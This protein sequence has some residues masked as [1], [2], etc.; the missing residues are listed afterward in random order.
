MGILV[1]RVRFENGP[2]SLDAIYDALEAR[3]GLTC[4]RGEVAQGYTIVRC[5]SIGAPVEMRFEEK[6]IALE[7][8][9]A[10]S[11][12]LFDQLREALVDLG[13][14]RCDAV[15]HPMAGGTVR[16]SPVPWAKTKWSSRLLDSHP[17]LASLLWIVLVVPK[18]IY[19]TARSRNRRV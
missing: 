17:V 3:T 18:A 10:Q 2:P 8:P 11:V 7:Q 4:R 12:Y 5:K 16:T 14:C 15:G 13:G 1:C 19:E 6:R 9:I